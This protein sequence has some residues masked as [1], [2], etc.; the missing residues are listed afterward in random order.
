MITLP[1]S[2]AKQ[3]IS[4]IEAK[5]YLNLNEAFELIGE[6]LEGENWHQMR[7]SHLSYSIVENLN[8]MIKNDFFDVYDG[9]DFGVKLNKSREADLLAE[10]TYSDFLTRLRNKDKSFVVVRDPVFIP[11]VR[12]TNSIRDGFANKFDEENKN[13][14]LKKRSKTTKEYTATVIHDEVLEINYSAFFPKNFLIPKE[15]FDYVLETGKR[16]IDKAPK[17][18]YG[19]LVVS[20]KQSGFRGLVRHEK[21]LKVDS[22]KNIL[23]FIELSSI[24]QKKFAAPEW[25]IDLWISRVND[26]EL[27]RLQSNKIDKDGYA[28]FNKQKANDSN[29]TK[30]FYLKTQAD[31]FVPE[32]FI[33]YRGLV[34][35]W[36]KLGISEEKITQHILNHLSS[37]PNTENAL[38]DEDKIFFSK[39]DSL[40]APIHKTKHGQLPWD[41]KD[42]DKQKEFIREAAF[43]ESYIKA[44]EDMY[45]FRNLQEKSNR[46]RKPKFDE[47]VVW[48]AFV[49]ELGGSF[50]ES[51]P[52]FAKQAY[53]AFDKLAQENKNSL[54]FIEKNRKSPFRKIIIN[55]LSEIAKLKSQKISD[56]TLGDKIA[57]KF[58]KKFPKNPR[59]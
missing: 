26:D 39:G 58:I 27:I 16:W 19:N 35:R 52:D 31:S 11:S 13:K 2:K 47:T 48:K 4:K 57:D 36:K 28:F 22:R 21:M 6:K 8:D 56:R 23:S 17:K 49:E 15:Q 14:S 32:R 43:G 20:E 38:P 54:G 9:D 24:Y 3:K 42:L 30:T 51:N 59:L 44:M 46:G 10:I 29:Y 45:S 18:E 12:I 41:L 40:K 7:G 37:P 5:N 1:S 53:D 25:E 55:K 34:N 50:D 33:D